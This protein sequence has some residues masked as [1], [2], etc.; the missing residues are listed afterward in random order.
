MEGT[1][2]TLVVGVKPLVCAVPIFWRPPNR[3]WIQNFRPINRRWGGWGR[4]RR[5]GWIRSRRRSWVL[6][7]RARLTGRALI[8][9]GFSLPWVA[10]ARLAA[11]ATPST[12]KRTRTGPHYTVPPERRTEER[13]V[14]QE[15]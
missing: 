6:W 15:G 2:K 8:E 10:S 11:T 4:C 9:P 12:A 1:A 14:G 5:T 13:R 7:G 3:L